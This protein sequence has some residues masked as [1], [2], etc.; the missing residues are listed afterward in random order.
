MAQTIKNPMQCGR[1]GFNPCVGKIP[2]RR[3][4]QPTPVFLP[5]EFHGQ[6]SL[7]SY[8]PWGRK[9]SDTTEWLSL[10]LFQLSRIRRKRGNSHTCYES[11][12]QVKTPLLSW[13]SQWL[14]TFFLFKWL[15]RNTSPDCGQISFS[16]NWQW[17]H[18]LI[19]H[20]HDYKTTPALE[21]MPF[22]SS[23]NLHE[24]QEVPVSEP[25]SFCVR[26]FDR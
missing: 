6:R 8:S 16:P 22:S 21:K 14:F 2:W 17:S 10:S 24:S 13:Q 25:I 9:D 19:A 11:R 3:A 23:G 26:P 7:A 12:A 1:P 20:P 4:W 5:G 15:E 18:T